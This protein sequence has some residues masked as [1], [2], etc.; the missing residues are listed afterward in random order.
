[1]HKAD[2]GSKDQERANFA[3]GLAHAQIAAFDYI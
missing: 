1:M 2:T 3:L